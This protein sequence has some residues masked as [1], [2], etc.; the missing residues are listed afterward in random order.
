MESGGSFPPRD[1]GH[2]V[3]RTGRSSARLLA[4][5][6]LASALV[7]APA[8]GAAPGVRG[9]AQE[10][11]RAFH[12]PPGTLASAIIAIG[13]QAGV[14]IA[15]TDPS[16]AHRRLTKPIEGRMTVE[17]ALACALRG[18]GLRAVRVAPGL[19]RVEHA[20]APPPL[21]PSPPT[22]PPPPPVEPAPAEIL[23][24]ATKRDTALRDYPGSAWVLDADRLTQGTGIVRDSR[25][26]VAALPVLSATSLGPGREKLFVRGVADSSF[27][28]A[29]Q[30]TVGQYLGD[31]QLNYSAPDPNLALYDMQRVEVLE[32][33]QGT[34]YGAGALGGIVRITP[35]APKPGRWEGEVAAGG[36]AVAHGDIGG[37]AMAMLNAPI[38]NRAALRLVG[39]GGRDPGYIDD[40]TRNRRNINRTDLAGGRGALR[41]EA[42]ND[43]TVDLGGVYQRIYHADGQYTE[44]GQAPLARAAAIAQPALNDFR[45]VYVTATHRWA[46][47][48]T[49]T[50]AASVIENH[51]TA[52]YD[53][54][55]P[56]D[57][58]PSGIATD[59][60]VRVYNGEIRL[61]RQRENGAGLVL[62]AYATLSDDRLTQ[63]L[64]MIGVDQPFRGVGNKV[65]DIALFGEATLPI[66]PRLRATIGGRAAY[67]D[68]QGTNILPD[69]DQ[70]LATIDVPGAGNVSFLPSAALNWDAGARWSAYLRYQRGYR[71]GGYA[72][73]ALTPVDTQSDADFTVYRPDTLDTVEVGVR[74]RE[75]GDGLSGGIALSTTDWRHIQSDLYTVT[76]PITVNIGSGRIHALEGHAQWRTPGGLRLSGALFLTR[77]VLDRPNPDFARETLQALPNTPAITARLAAER[78][79]RLGD[80]SRL[81]LRGNARYVGRSWLGVGDLHLPQGNY[82]ELN[83]GVAWSKGPITVSLDVANLLDG[84]GN[85]FALGNPL[86]VSDG[87]QRTPQQPRT[88]RIGAGYRF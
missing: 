1:A 71:L 33:P 27:T 48:Q 21:P 64:K 38:G 45:L 56:G 84:R 36:T 59:N 87:T 42:G 80:D 67:T 53:G 43:W 51:L 17:E 54:T 70:A 72:L 52:L 6:T 57:A 25:A 79:W 83:G 58:A 19:Y 18:S 2:R 13:S 44:E 82:A 50:A 73:N 35:R 8:L 32:G 39:Y 7:A 24:T 68:L 23:V 62:G 65:T 86:T 16:L 9:Q 15:T 49:L 46:S 60:R 12:V 78:D 37:D 22:P 69:G 63:S 11:R 14:S 20:P 29:S 26:I 10:A 5:W 76:G 75:N 28:G 61:A 47:G 30:A 85:R 31:V 55:I 4:G 34:L 88:L 81:L 74:L 40:V 41:L 66:L 77:A 3:T